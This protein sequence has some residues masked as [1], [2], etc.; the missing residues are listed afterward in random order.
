MYP[1]QWWFFPGMQGRF[2]IWKESN[3]T[4][5]INTLTKENDIMFSTDGKK[6]IF[7]IKSFL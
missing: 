5:H 3:V 2:I 7:M 1:D 4:H 6:C